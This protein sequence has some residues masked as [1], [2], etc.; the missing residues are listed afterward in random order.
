MS[1]G[2]A[3]INGGSS[4]IKFSVFSFDENK[5]LTPCFEGQV[6]GI[7]VAPKFVAK[8]P[9]G[10]LLKEKRWEN[11]PDVNHRSLLDY[12]MK[13]TR[14]NIGDIEVR[15]VG[16]RVVHGGEIYSS[17]VCVDESVIDN[18]ESFIPLA[19]LHQPHN[20]V[21]IRTINGIRFYFEKARYFKQAL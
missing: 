1:K 8:N 17:P 4:S 11:S 16:H 14:E 12:L 3:V 9:D 18:L 2:I 5:P 7:G 21:P 6:D 10:E 20:L 13:W 19:P 15:A